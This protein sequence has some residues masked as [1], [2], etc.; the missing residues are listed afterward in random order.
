MVEKFEAVVVGAGPAGLAAA[1]ELARHGTQV[2][3]L[4]RGKYPGAKNV[5]GGILYGQSNSPFNMDYLFPDFE[6]RAPLER[7]ISK[8]LMHNIAGD[9]VKTLDISPLHHYK[10]SYAW[11]VLRN[12][13]DRWFGD[14][15]AKEAR[16]HGG[17][18]LNNIEVTGPLL[19]DGKI[20]G[21][22]S[23]E[24][25]DIKADVVIAADG[26][27]S[28]LV[29]TA[30]L[31]DWGPEEHWFQGVKVVAK[32]PKDLLEKQFQVSGNEGTA[33][34]FAGDLFGGC[35]GGGFLYTNKETL[36]I[37]TVFHLDSITA[38]KKEPH[39][40]LDK[41]LSHPFMLNLLGGHYDEAEY[42]A[43]LIPDGKKNA[44]RFPY[45]DNLLA[46]GDAAGQMKAAGP[47]IKGMNLGISAGILAGQAFL[48]AKQQ[49]RIHQTGALYG[50]YLA[51]SYVGRELF[52]R[53]FMRRMASMKWANRMLE[54][55]VTRPSFLRSKFGQKRVQKMVSSYRMASIAPDNEFVYVNLP[56]SVAK[57]LGQRVESEIMAPKLPHIDER[58]AA[59]TYDTDIGRE[60]IQLLD[61]SV[62][63]SGIA[64]TTCPVSSPD[65]S[66]GCYRLEKTKDERGVEATR[67]VLDTQPCVECGTCAIVAATKWNHP[68]GG[69]GVQYELG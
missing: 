64:V 31:R 63:A 2:L 45:K 65:S 32:M 28:S 59:L 16:K 3:V 26:A 56:T 48:V 27:T 1:Y 33:H 14:E 60:H 54:G 10:T 66:R 47:I 17:G 19:E 6:K 38:K 13:F 69:K 68:H 58:I 53:R 21:V 44:I 40:Y 8:Y 41:L 50:T 49:R 29:R 11:S 57:E 62:K 15:V 4:E 43:K 23:N 20:V 5:T 67:V 7:D 46:I 61:S 24:L 9:K 36:S 18:I 51:S 12:G 52:G 22:K 37:G 55:Y 42:S 39:K 34:L 25:D 35:R 30:G